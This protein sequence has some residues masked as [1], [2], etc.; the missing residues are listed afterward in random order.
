MKILQVITIILCV[1]AYGVEVEA[2]ACKKG[3][4]CGNSCISKNK[5]CRIG[6]THYSPK[7]VY[8]FPQSSK[9]PASP[10]SPSVSYGQPYQYDYKTPA[11]SKTYAVKA[12]S[13]N[14]REKPSTTAKIIGTLIRGDKIPV[15]DVSG[16]WGAVI[17]KGE[18]GWIHLNFLE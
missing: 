10:S 4:P 7:R 5:T 9:D 2:K 6:T 12:S 14:V 17:Y 13:L 11:R 15:F 8:S 1:L 18:I 16:E 3:K